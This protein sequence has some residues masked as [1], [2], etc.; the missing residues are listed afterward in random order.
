MG[1]IGI[2][3]DGGI[4]N[5]DD[6]GNPI[7]ERIP[8]IYES[9]YIISQNKT[10]KFDSG[11]FIVDWYN[12]MK[13]FYQDLVNNEPNLSYSSSVNHFIMDG[14][15]YDSAYLHFENENSVLKYCDGLD[16]ENDRKI[17]EYG[18]EL[19]VEKNTRQSYEEYKK[20]IRTWTGTNRT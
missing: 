17:Y 1:V 11:N 2:N 18:L 9:V 12:A 16:F 8:I 15:P 4:Q 10:Y 5:Y 7:G 20:N 13:K 3:Y 14:A 6:N 19:F